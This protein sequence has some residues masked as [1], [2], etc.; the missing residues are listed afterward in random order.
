MRVSYIGSYCY[1]CCV[2]P[3][4]ALLSVTQRII[5]GCLC[6]SGYPEN[7]L[8]NTHQT[9]LP[10]PS[11][12][13][14]NLGVKQCDNNHLRSFHSICQRFRSSASGKQGVIALRKQHSGFLLFISHSS[15][16]PACSLPTPVDVQPG[17]KQG[18]K[19]PAGGA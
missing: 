17:P 7:N 11:S 5:S 15:I 3:L 9:N 4:C 6:N 8:L 19:E 14:Y 1:S 2:S 13:T 10:L 16:L 18:R 12:N